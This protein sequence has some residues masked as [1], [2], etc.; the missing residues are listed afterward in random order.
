VDPPI[1]SELSKHDYSD[2]IHYEQLIE[3]LVDSDGCGS[4]DEYIWGEII[5]FIPKSKYKE[6][7]KLMEQ[8][9]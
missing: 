3:I 2:S 5:S 6:L 8:N 1:E 4:W 7:E 9:A